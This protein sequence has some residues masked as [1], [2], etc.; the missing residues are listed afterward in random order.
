MGEVVSLEGH[1]RDRDGVR[2]PLGRIEARLH[3][4]ISILREAEA[5]Q[6]ALKRM[7]A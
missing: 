7:D 5:R 6:A 4:I 3:D 2:D 1:R